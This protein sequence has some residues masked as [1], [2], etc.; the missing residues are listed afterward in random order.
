MHPNTL[1]LVAALRKYVSLE[2]QVKVAGAIC[3]DFSALPSAAVAKR[4]LLE[5]HRTLLFHLGY[6]HGPAFHKGPLSCKTDQGR[7]EAVLSTDRR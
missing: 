6:E 4:P 1:E 3:S 5:N 2:G 7:R